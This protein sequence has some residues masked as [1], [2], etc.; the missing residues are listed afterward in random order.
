VYNWKRCHGTE[1]HAVPV[2]Q[3][4]RVLRAS[5]GPITVGSSIIVGDKSM[6]HTN[7]GESH[8]WAT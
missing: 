8:D 2:F 1:Q 5:E 3:G 6:R 4:H 7:A